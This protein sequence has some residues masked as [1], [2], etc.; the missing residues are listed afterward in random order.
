MHE[1]V[2]R[3]TWIRFVTA[4]VKWLLFI[5]IKSGK[6]ITDFEEQP[7]TVLV[8]LEAE[9]SSNKTYLPEKYTKTRCETAMTRENVNIRTTKLVLSAVLVQPFGTASIGIF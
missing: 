6:L 7:D 3:N 2:I 8:I 4:P 9:Q 1:Q 5:K